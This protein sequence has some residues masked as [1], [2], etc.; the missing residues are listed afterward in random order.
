MEP[1]EKKRS[2]IPKHYVIA[3]RNSLVYATLVTAGILIVWYLLTREIHYLWK[4][5]VTVIA[6][7]AVTFYTK[8]KFE[9][10]LTNDTAQW[11]PIA[12]ASIIVGWSIYVTVFLTEPTF[13]S[14]A[15]IPI[16]ILFSLWCIAV[17]LDAK[18][19]ENRTRLILMLFLTHLLISAALG[20]LVAYA[21]YTFAFPPPD[22]TE[23]KTEMCKKARSICSPEELTYPNIN[24][25]QNRN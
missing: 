23:E 9:N 6:F 24:F 13:E 11:A 5:L 4:I 12:A 20:F 16:G 7:I 1:K 8:G 18:E 14:W 2:G 15:L 19:K 22:E 10:D 17:T 3:A 21:Y 25:Q